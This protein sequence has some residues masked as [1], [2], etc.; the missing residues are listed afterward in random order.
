MNWSLAKSF[1]LSL[2][3][4]SAVQPVKFRGTKIVHDV[5]AID[6][7]PL[8]TLDYSGIC[9]DDIIQ[10]FRSVHFL[11]NFLNLEFYS[12]SH[13]FDTMKKVS[14]NLAKYVSEV[15]A[16]LST[17]KKEQ[18]TLPQY[19]MHYLSAKFL[20]LMNKAR[21]RC[22]L[23][24]L[25]ET[26]SVME[27]G[28]EEA[29]RGKFDGIFELKRKILDLNFL[30]AARDQLLMSREKPT[31]EDTDGS[32]KEVEGG[33][34]YAAAFKPFMDN[35][36]DT[37]ANILKT[38]Q[39][40]SDTNAITQREDYIINFFLVF[41]ELIS[42]QDFGQMV[43]EHVVGADKKLKF[44]D[45]TAPKMLQNLALYY[46]PQ[47]GGSHKLI[48]VVDELFFHVN[49]E[50]KNPLK[51]L[52]RKNIYYTHH[53]EW[54][55]FFDLD[56]KRPH[57]PLDKE[58]PN[59]DDFFDN[60]HKYIYYFYVDQR[61]KGMVPE[62]PMEDPEQ[63]I[64]RVANILHDKLLTSECFKGTVDDCTFAQLID[65][66]DY[67]K[68]YLTMLVLLRGAAKIPGD[69]LTD[70][71]LRKVIEVG[72]NGGLEQLNIGTK[73]IAKALPTFAQKKGQM[74]SSKLGDKISN[75]LGRT[76]ANKVS[77]DQETPLDADEVFNELADA[78]KILQK[79]DE[80]KK[81]L[82]DAIKQTMPS[83]D[84]DSTDPDVVEQQLQ[85]LTSLVETMPQMT[86]DQRIFIAETVK[87]KYQVIRNRVPLQA[88]SKNGAN[89][90]KLRVK[91][92]DDVIRN[93]IQRTGAKVKLGFLEYLSDTLTQ[94]YFQQNKNKHITNYFN[95]QDYNFLRELDIFIF[96]YNV[97]IMMNPD[98]V[99]EVRDEIQKKY[100]KINFDFF[101][102]EKLL[103][104]YEQSLLFMGSFLSFF[105]NYKISNLGQEKHCGLDHIQ[106]FHKVY[107][108]FLD[109]RSYVLKAG[110]ART[111]VGNYREFVITSL[112]R[113]TKSTY[114]Q[115]VVSTNKEESAFYTTRFLPSEYCRLS[116]DAENTEL[117]GN[118]LQAW[119]K[120]T[121][122]KIDN[123]ENKMKNYRVDNRI[124]QHNFAFYAEIYPLLL[125]YVASNSP[126]PVLVAGQMF[127]G[128][129]LPKVQLVN[130]HSFFRYL[131]D[132]NEQHP[133][134]QM[135]NTFCSISIDGETF[136]KVLKLKQKD[137]FEVS[138][139]VI[140]SGHKDYVDVGKYLKDLKTPSI[141]TS[142][143]M[144]KN[145]LELFSNFK[146]EGR[147]N[148]ESVLFR[149]W[150]QVAWVG[151]SDS[152]PRSETTADLSA[153]IQSDIEASIMSSDSDGF[154][155]AL[156]TYK[157]GIADIIA[158][159]TT[160]KLANAYKSIHMEKK[161]KMVAGVD[162]IFSTNRVDQALVHDDELYRDGLS[163]MIK[164]ANC[165]ENFDRLAKI[166]VEMDEVSNIY[167]YTEEL[168]L[169]F[170]SMAEVINDL[171]DLNDIAD[172]II[173]KFITNHETQSMKNQKLVEAAKRQASSNDLEFGLG[174]DDF[175][176]N[177]SAYNDDIEDEGQIE[178]DIG[179]ESVEDALGVYKERRPV[180]I[181][182]VEEDEVVKGGV[183]VKMTGESS[184]FIIA[185]DGT[186]I[187]HLN[188]IA[189]AKV[190]EI[191]EMKNHLRRR[192][193][194]L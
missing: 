167:T 12:K 49:P 157:N 23:E 148:L 19:P 173:T 3:L 155:Q 95:N 81:D 39:E 127:T 34:A 2:C 63:Q 88:G 123:F 14:T 108:F 41:G 130:L 29:M 46:D 93:I 115:T 169:M 183:S 125:T 65:R 44:N 6:R 145:V 140:C 178:E 48:L 113:C 96:Y 76:S 79:K 132:Q 22:N 31:Y 82:V 77:L 147:E 175:L 74:M 171:T 17:L 9:N 87:E 188:Q 94:Q 83:L 180:R 177:A 117:Q 30:I 8:L 110:K 92:K 43:L 104:E 73:P 151:Q 190:N 193:V 114:L 164:Y 131:S 10:H 118:V 170:H 53:P 80:I 16:Y 182:E 72:T 99:K 42:A 24:K 179:F 37:L 187:N 98:K 64:Q 172:T 15:E 126:T 122:T 28:G 25:P 54:M 5:V 105:D 66:K 106:L 51:I 32:L 189:R 91:I 62:S 20:Y 47:E 139:S 97:K 185:V 111:L 38:L 146:A 176:N 159:Y 143:V 152:G 156:E 56:G 119:A 181:S 52:Q 70:D 21:K 50:L 68:Y 120:R 75:L 109:L 90:D 149:I 186:E 163:F 133:A 137:S 184:S 154:R 11:K 27:Q 55:K 61:L 150:D 85:D 116:R 36:H 4:I 161:R 69:E 136:R 160:L 35:L 107:F 57:S 166:M 89:L 33:E 138:K 45:H 18:Q 168:P 1:V 67:A 124:C 71:Q 129:H 84:K 26:D 60:G 142:K 40:K 128:V 59:H 112:H 141:Q 58:L 158:K 86:N 121:K 165:P 100:Q 101:S 144:I 102:D 13:P 162:H 153:I 194:L 191:I 192:R 134:R 174:D 135:H 78:E 103:F 7:L